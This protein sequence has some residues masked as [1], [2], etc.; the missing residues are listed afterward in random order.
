MTGLV[1]WLKHLFFDLLSYFEYIYINLGSLKAC[2]LFSGDIYL[3]SGVLA[4]NSISSVS[5]ETLSLILLPIKLPVAYAVLWI[6]LFEAILSASG[7]DC[8]WLQH[9]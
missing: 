5:L 3:F 1:F 2:F 7:A 4:S 8:S 9:N 6:A